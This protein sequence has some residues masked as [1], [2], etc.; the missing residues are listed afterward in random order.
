[1]RTYRVESGL[2]VEAE[3]GAQPGTPHLRGAELARYLALPADFPASVRALARRFVA[4]TYTPYD[5]AIALQDH[6]RVGYAYYQ[7]ARPG[8]SNADLEYF[9]FRSL[10]GYCEQ[11][12]GAFAAMARSLGL[13]AR[14]AVG[15]TPGTYDPD[16]GVW[17]VT[18]KEAHAWPEL[19]LEGLGWVPFEPTPGR[20]QP[21]QDDGGTNA[22]LAQVRPGSARHRAAGDASSPPAARV[23]LNGSRARD[24]GPPKGNLPE[25]PHLPRWLATLPLVLASGLL[26]PPLAKGA[27]RRARRAGRRGERVAAAWR[28]ALDRLAE[29]GL[30]PRGGE[31]PLEFA[32]RAGHTRPGT[33]PA[34]MRLAVLMN[35]FAYAPRPPAAASAGHAWTA[36][37]HLVRALDAGDTPWA[38]WRRRLDPRPL[39]PG[40]GA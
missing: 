10:H 24:A 2:P 15:F 37:R 17:R 6:L 3:A 31:T 20:A 9:L 16:A 1:V 25:A 26:V 5:Q 14:V 39:L 11:F 19:Y 28:E 29:V 38:R 23:L 8:H 22:L 12:A 33:G 32:G 30:A 13:P 4:G 21:S 27:R 34:L 36:A 18:T 35:G 7:E 40:R